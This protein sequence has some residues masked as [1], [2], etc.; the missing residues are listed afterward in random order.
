[1]TGRRGILGGLFLAH[2]I[3]IDL[4]VESERWGYLGIARESAPLTR[5]EYWQSTR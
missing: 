5:L 3:F 2:G 4:A 1:M